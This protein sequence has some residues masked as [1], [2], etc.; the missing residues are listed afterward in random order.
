MSPLNKQQLDKIRDER[1]E[2]IKKAALNV[3][4]RYGYSGTKTNTI[5][6]QAGISEGLI[7][8][9]FNSKEE[10][11]N[12]LVKELL[13]EARREFKN[14]HYLQGSPFEQIKALTENMISQNN[15][16]AFVL[17][18]RARKDDD[19][20]EKTTEI[21]K[22]FSTDTLADLLVPIFIKGQEIGEFSVEDPHRLAS[23]YFFVINSICMQEAEKE[24]YGMPNVEILMRMLEK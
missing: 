12:T 1:K 2:Q 20:P 4:A 23:W 15:R 18:Q 7:Y 6:S 9:Y 21:L 19:I 16:H 8:R 5:A 17:V 24:Q 13:E 3:F 10:I 22:E 11:F 14:L